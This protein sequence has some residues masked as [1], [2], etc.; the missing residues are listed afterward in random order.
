MTRHSGRCQTKIRRQPANPP[1]ESRRWPCRLFLPANTALRLTDAGARLLLSRRS[2]RA[3]Q[4]RTVVAARARR[5]RPANHRQRQ[6]WRG[7]ACGCCHGWAT[8]QAHPQ[9]DMR[10]AGRQPQAQTRRRRVD[11]RPSATT[12]PTP[13]RPMR[14]RCLTKPGRGGPAWPRRAQP[15]GRAGRTPALL[16]FDQPGPPG[17]PGRIGW[18]RRVNAWRMLRFNPIRP[19]DSRRAVARPGPGAGARLPLPGH[20]LAQWHVCVASRRRLAAVCTSSLYALLRAAEAA[21]LAVAQDGGMVTNSRAAQTRK[22]T[23]QSAGERLS[24]GGVSP[25]QTALPQNSGGASAAADPAAGDR[26]QRVGKAIMKNA[27]W[28]MAGTPICAGR[29]CSR[30]RRQPVK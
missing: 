3:P 7:L 18:R 15:A 21:S 8:W 4:A 1:A 26:P 6:H 10:L 17:Y 28:P 27:K 22:R 20:L 23:A 5:R 29:T 2:R 19:A 30:Q 24:A 14:C 16:T 9:L 13:C 12:P 11:L 25:G